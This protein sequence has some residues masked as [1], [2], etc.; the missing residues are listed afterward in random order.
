MTEIQM[1]ITGA[2]LSFL[3]MRQVWVG[4]GFVF[5]WFFGIVPDEYLAYL[6]LASAGIV[7]FLKFQKTR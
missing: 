7:L 5:L 3:A 1:M 4:V 6:Y 2:F